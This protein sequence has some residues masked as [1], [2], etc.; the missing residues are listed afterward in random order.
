MT[1]T[2]PLL[3]L[4]GPSA[5][6]KTT[7]AEALLARD[8]RLSL[9]RSVTTREPRDDRFAGEYIY[10]DRAEF[11]R[12]R[13]AGELV[14]WMEYGGQ[15]YGT[16]VSE[17]ARIRAQGQIPLLILDLV[18]VHSARTHT[19][20]LPL[21]TVYLWEELDVMEQRLYDRT[22]AVAPSVEGL[23][24]FTERR[25]ANIR[26]YLTLSERVGEFDVMLHADGEVSDL[27]DQVLACYA[28]GLRTP[29]ENVRVTDA[30]AEM[31]REK[32]QRSYRRV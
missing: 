32:S 10:L 22:L 11:E 8:G 2:H 5:V 18:G 26:D 15:L 9:V 17:L 27:A 29:E 7:V 4:A 3:I 20:P 1:Q 14:E 31:A 25:E 13:E 6:G 28:D 12:R 23:T 30:L 24:T 16:P 21:Y 19:P